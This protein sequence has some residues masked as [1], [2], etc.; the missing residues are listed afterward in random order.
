MNTADLIIHIHPELN[1]DARKDLE[2]RLESHVGIDCAEFIHQ[3]HPHSLV[4]KYD[5]DAIQGMEILQV[6][7]QTD[8]AA[9]MSGL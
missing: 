6:V 9:T 2:K 1:A 4:V 7:R 5:P 3:P 8:P